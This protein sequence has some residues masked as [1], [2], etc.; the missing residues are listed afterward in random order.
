MEENLTPDEE[1]EDDGQG[2][3][4]NAFGGDDSEPGGSGNANIDMLLDIPL[5]IHVRLGETKMALRDVLKLAPGE[6]IRLNRSEG[7]GVE[8]YVNGRMIATGQIIQTPEGNIG[9]EIGSIV[10]RAE[11]LRSVK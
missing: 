7:D 1:T 6:I 9:V 4:E 5:S 11:R 3:F 10:T 2:G 8:L